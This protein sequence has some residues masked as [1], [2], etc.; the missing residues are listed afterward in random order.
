MK[1]NDSFHFHTSFITAHIRS[2]GKVMFSVCLLTEGV[3]PGQGPEGG[4]PRVHPKGQGLEGGAPRGTPQVNVWVAPAGVPP[5]SR[6]GAPGVP[7][8]VKV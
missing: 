1:I 3:P 7:P 2:M 4:A 8:K 5:R 6:S